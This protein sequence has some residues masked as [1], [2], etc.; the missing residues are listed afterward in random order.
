M[1]GIHL[2][3]CVCVACTCGMCGTVHV[4]GVWV[5][6]D[7]YWCECMYVVHV[8]VVCLYMGV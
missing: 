7:V 1:C 5:C 8:Y 4:C 6:G 2:C 3:V